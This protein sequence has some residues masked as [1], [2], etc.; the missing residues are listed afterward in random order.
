MARTMTGGDFTPPQQ[1]EFA[2][3][4]AIVER[5]V[6]EAQQV[7][8]YGMPTFKYRGKVIVHVGAFTD[9]MSLFPGGIVERFADDLDGFKTS[10]G[11]I[12]FTLEKTLPAALIQ[13]IVLTRKRM[14]EAG[15]QA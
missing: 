5:N 1:A 13:K 10:K 6:P 12:Q 7:V 14:I 2:R 11:T 15:E 3:I 4:K 9:H 8:S